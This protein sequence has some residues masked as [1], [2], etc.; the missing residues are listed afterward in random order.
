MMTNFLNMPLNMFPPGGIPVVDVR[1]VAKIHAAVMEPERGPRRYMSSGNYMDVKDGM[2]LLSELT[3]RSIRLLT[4]PAWSLSPVVQFSHLSQKVMPFRL[5]ISK[6]AF[7]MVR[8]D[9]HCDDSKTKSEL[10]VEY[11]DL[12]ETVSDMISWMHEKGGI[13]AKLAGKLASRN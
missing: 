3:G 8:W 1:D 11:R 10:G 7:D 12:R 4:M 5:P 2:R 6:E 13:S 9:I